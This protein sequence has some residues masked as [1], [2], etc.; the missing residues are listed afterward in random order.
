MSTDT[1]NRFAVGDPGHT[2][3]GKMGGRI[4]DP[5]LAE[6]QPRAEHVFSPT[7][8]DEHAHDLTDHVRQVTSLVV[9]NDL[10]DVVLA[11]HSYGGMVITGVAASLAGRVRGMVYVDAALPEP[12]ESL[13]DVIRAGG[14]DP[15]SFA[16]LE[17]APPY[18]QELRF[19]P[20]YWA[21]VP[22]TYVLC[23]ESEFL[24]VTQVA[25]ERIADGEAAGSW[26]Y[27]ELP[28]WHV[29]MANM[30]ERVAEILLDA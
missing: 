21:S 10:H 16:G 22:K 30:P 17:A 9:D 6:L 2:P 13:F 20:A 28:T 4:W 8:G 11:G 29:P 7:L 3:D 19:D 26:T 18:V 27:I 5:L 24:P 1:W 23:T 12:G 15:L 14:R 25:K